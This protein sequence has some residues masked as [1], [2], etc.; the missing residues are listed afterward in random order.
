MSRKKPTRVSAETLAE[1]QRTISVA[2]FFLKNRHLLGFDS[3]ERALLTTVKEAVDNSLDACEEASILPEIRVEV[4]RRLGR[5]QAQV[6]QVAIEDNG[7]GIVEA[8]VARIFGKLLYG[9]RFHKRAQSR[10][11]Q[12]MGI[13]AAGMYAEL[14]TGK[15]IRIVTRTSPGKKAREMLVSI[16]TSR[17]R[18]DIHA[19]RDTDWDV[20]HGTRVELELEGQYTHGQHSILLYLK[21]TSIANP[22]VVIHLREP[23]GNEITFARTVRKKPRAPRTLKPHPHGLELG[24]LISMLKRTQAKSLGR[25][26]TRELSQVGDK[27]AREIIARA[28]AGLT[29][30]SY[31][32]RIARE[33]ARSLLEALAETPV[34]APPKGAVVPIGEAA[35]S[36]GLMHEIPA[37]FHA[38]TTRPPAV[39][40]GN[41][42]VVEVGIA[43]GRKDAPHV[44]VTEDGHLREVGRGEATD[45]HG[46]AKLLRFANRAPLLYEQGSCAITRSV[47]DTSLRRYGVDH[48][49]GSLPLGP[50]VILVHVASV[51]VP[52][53]SES[54]E[55]VAAF[56]ELSH[57]IALGLQDVGRKLGAYLHKERRLE[58]ELEKR[59]TIERYLPHVGDAVS[60]ILGLSGDDRA[61]FVE[62]LD[63]VV[64]RTRSAP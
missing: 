47:M 34:S 56:P 51:W 45:D 12:G 13:S 42:F 20:K 17:N 3:R 5:G 10:G 21:L 53:T 57:E 62:Q 16:D 40:H 55:A 14:T 61:R 37:A 1:G 15:P 28:D 29:T 24:D 36:K 44:V 41:P 39:H 25:F 9:S 30:R 18:P 60:G 52:F 19:K 33:K 43:W 11:Q 7:P 8:Q 48:P 26:L 63:N 58:D 23:N 54:K 38:V 32:K 59:T 2:E 6:Y 64:N 27:R 49:T 46:P 35:I 31:P 4:T 50:M 22:H